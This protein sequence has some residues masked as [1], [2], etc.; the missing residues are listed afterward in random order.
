MF[1]VNKHLQI[2]QLLSVNILDRNHYCPTCI[3]NRAG[4]RT[5]TPPPVSA[6]NPMSI[7]QE[8]AHEAGGTALSASLRARE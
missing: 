1:S 2:R 5:L 3:E 6:G 4:G 8:M 7:D